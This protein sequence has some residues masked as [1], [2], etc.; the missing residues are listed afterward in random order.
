MSLYQEVLAQT[1]DLFSFYRY[2][3]NLSYHYFHPNFKEKAFSSPSYIYFSQS[4]RHHHYYVDKRLTQYV[5]E[6]LIHNNLKM[7]HF[8][9]NNLKQFNQLLDFL[10][11]YPMKDFISIQC[12]SSPIMQ[13]LLY[14]NYISN[15]RKRKEDRRVERCDITKYQGGYGFCGEWLDLF[16]T[17]TYFYSYQTITKEDI[18]QFLILKKQ[19]FYKPDYTIL[20]T[21]FLEVKPRNIKINPSLFNHYEKY[22]LMNSLQQIIENQ[23]FFPTS[24][25]ETH[26]NEIMKQ[27][28]SQYTRERKRILSLIDS[29]FEQNM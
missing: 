25:F 10:K 21:F 5:N 20:P 15:V 18:L 4:M 28:I 26:S 24:P 23:L 16:N 12:H 1:P 29:T 9:F 11:T 19:Y 3:G 27:V 22:E 8:S 14:K 13:A 2:E 17:L 6:I 7:H